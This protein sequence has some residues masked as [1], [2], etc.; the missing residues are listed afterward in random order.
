[1][2]GSCHSLQPAL[3]S[4][5]CSSTS[6]SSQ[7]RFPNSV[8]I[9]NGEVAKRLPMSLDL[10]ACRVLLTGGSGFLGGYVLTQLRELGRQHVLA[11]RRADFDLTCW[12]DVLR[13]L[14]K[15][16]PDL[17]LHL[18]ARV[19]GIGANQKQPGTFLYQNLMMGAHLIEAS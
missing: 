8:L 11:P 12:E 6:S 5:P 16:R 14:M 7:E 19:G 2:G 10:T 4:C 3:L 18:A 1:M 15:T 9:G 17:V 13:L